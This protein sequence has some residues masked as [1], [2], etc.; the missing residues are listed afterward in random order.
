MDNA[1]LIFN[2]VSGKGDP[3]SQLAFIRETFQQADISLTVLETTPDL[4]ASELSKRAIV[5][6]ADC[7]IA[8]GGDGT[9]SAVAGELCS[10]DIPLAI[11]P[12]GTANAI[13]AAF[14]ISN[15]IA[16]ACDVILTGTARRI[17]MAACNGK[18][19][20]LLAGIGLEADVIAK[21]N[22][23]LKNKIGSAAYILSAFQQV[24]D[25][26]AFKAELETPRRIITVEASG[27]TVANTAPATSVLA[28]GPSDVVPYDGLLD[29]TIFAPQGTGGAIAASY[30]L[31]QSALNN[32]SS[33]REDVGYFRCKK[34]TITT[35]PAQKVVLDGEMIGKTPVTIECLPQTISLI[36]PKDG[37]FEPPERLCDLPGLTITQKEIED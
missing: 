23:Q 7:V 35:D 14:G 27:L 5:E 11:I 33:R 31:F 15:N 28:H 4:S 6:S 16:A 37:I 1:Y 22:R 30:N 36:T 21:A 10:S 3:A 19:L 13:A 17:D 18:P 34:V 25:L 20:L 29:V 9:V 12:R 32:S 26:S 8:S 24:Q 2:P